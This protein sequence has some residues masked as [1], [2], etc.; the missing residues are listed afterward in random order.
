[1]KYEKQK[2]IVFDLDGTAFKRFLPLDKK[3]ISKKFDKNI[4]VKV[5]DSICRKINDADIIKNTTNILFLRFFV[6]SLFVPI[7]V[8][9]SEIEEYNNSWLVKKGYEEKVTS[10]VS[11]LLREYKEWYVREA[12]LAIVNCFEKDF[13]PLINLGYHIIIMS[14]N[15]LAKELMNMPYEIIVG[16]SKLI[17]L[18]KLLKD[19]VLDIRYFVGNNYMDDICNAYILG[20]NA[21]YVGNGYWVKNSKKLAISARTLKQSVFKIKEKDIKF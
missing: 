20:I 7:S 13:K 16:K 14:N 8:K 21:V 18:K 4:I 9:R 6:Y 17:E 10:Y 12:A 11:L 1:M 2:C 5:I 15:E 3:F 19:P